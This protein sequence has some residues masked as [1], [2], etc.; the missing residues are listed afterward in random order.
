MNRRL[1]VF[2]LLLVTLAALLRLGKLDDRPVHGDEAVNC[3][4]LDLLWQSGHYVYNPQEFH[5]PTLYYFTLPF[6]ALSGAENLAE[7]SSRTFRWVTVLFGVSLILLLLFL[8]DGLGQSATLGAAALLAVSPAMTYY[9]RF[10]IHEMLLCF[11]TL[12]AIAAAWRYAQGARWGGALGLGATLGLMQA[13]KET[14]VIAFSSML[15]AVAGT[16]AWEHIGRRSD[17]SPV[18]TTLRRSAGPVLGAAV[19]MAGVSILLYS[20]FFTHADGPLDS[21]RAYRN[22]W[23]RTEADTLHAHPWRNRFEPPPLRGI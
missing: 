8:V 16:I 4:K 1:A 15:L 22:Y 17:S 2:F 20:A 6:V 18:T 19:V 10:Y 9:S 7:T 12:A 21:L 23:V 3:S 13:T 14:C 5:G 11:F